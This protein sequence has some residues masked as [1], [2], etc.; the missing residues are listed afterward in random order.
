MTQRNICDIRELLNR[1]KGK[2]LNRQDDGFS[3]VAA[4]LTKQSV[5]AK[6]ADTIAKIKIKLVKRAI[7]LF[8]QVLPGRWWRASWRTDI[9]RKSNP[10]Y[11]LRSAFRHAV[12]KQISNWKAKHQNLKRC[13]NCKSNVDLQ[14]DHVFPPFIT[15]CTDFLIY[16]KDIVPDNFDYHSLGRKFRRCNN[17]FCRKWQSYHSTHCRLQWLCQT[18]NI[19]KGKKIQ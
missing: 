10:E 11:K 9:S 8:V 14:V 2:I 12:R 6:Y 1:Y 4:I 7:C 15:L 19:S 13:V 17:A 3:Q 5:W 18:C 16:Q